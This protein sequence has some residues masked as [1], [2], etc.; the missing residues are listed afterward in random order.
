MAIN[1][2]YKEHFK[3]LVY[4]TLLRRWVMTNLWHI[5]TNSVCVIRFYSRVL[6]EVHYETGFYSDFSGEVGSQFLVSKL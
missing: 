3:L 2:F 5:I 4:I 1:E 6:E